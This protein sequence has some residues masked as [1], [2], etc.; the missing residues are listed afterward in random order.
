MDASATHTHTHWLNTVISKR[1]KYVWLQPTP[2]IV[3]HISNWTS[4]FKTSPTCTE[5][6]ATSKFSCPW[7]LSSMIEQELASHFLGR[8]NRMSVANPRVEKPDWKG[9]KQH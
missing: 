1:L 6:A 4:V 8:R 5:A 9:L 3:L 2:V 7:D